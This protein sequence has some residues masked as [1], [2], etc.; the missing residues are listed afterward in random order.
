[1]RASRRQFMQ[2]LLGVGLAACA[3]ELPPP[4]TR[5][6]ADSGS[7]QADAEVLVVG[8]GVAG[9]AAARALVK[10]GRKVTLHRPQRGEKRA[11]VEHAETNAR[12]AL[13]KG[14]NSH[15]MRPPWA[16]CGAPPL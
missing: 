16:G 1:M 5:T 9:L 12:E 7:A 13:E 15:G 2:G 11:V 4:T 6:T 3:R 8:A 14:R 10:A